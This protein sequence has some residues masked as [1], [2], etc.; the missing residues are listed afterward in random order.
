MDVKSYIRKNLQSY[1]DN[2]HFAF[3]KQP[4]SKSIKFKDTRAKRLNILH[5]GAKAMP[6]PRDLGYRPF[7]IDSDLLHSSIQLENDTS[8]LSTQRRK[9]SK[10]RTIEP[11]ILPASKSNRRHK[12]IKKEKLEPES[13]TESQKARKAEEEEQERL[14][15]EEEFKKQ[16]ELRKKREYEKNA[17]FD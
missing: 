13:D 4:L 2:D 3:S 9:V 12:H 14:R 6:S 17:T 7:V 15:K 11:I 10:M 8:L 16:E 1:A 5:G